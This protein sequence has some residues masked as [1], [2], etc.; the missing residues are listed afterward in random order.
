MCIPIFPQR[1]KVQV[2]KVKVLSISFQS[3]GFAKQR[4]FS[5]KIELISESMGGINILFTFYLDF[6][7]LVPHS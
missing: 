1:C 4:F 3:P 2:Q 7:H 5:Q 6:T